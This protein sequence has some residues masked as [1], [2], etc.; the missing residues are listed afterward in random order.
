MDEAHWFQRWLDGAAHYRLSY[1]ADPDDDVFADETWQKATPQWEK[2]PYLIEEIKRHR[3]DARNDSD[4]FQSYKALRLN[5]GVPDVHQEVL[6]TA[7]DWKLCESDMEL[8]EGPLVW[9]IDMGGNSAMSAITGYWPVTGWFEKLAAFP[10]IPDL[11]KRGNQDGVG[12]MYNQMHRAGELIITEGRTVDPSILMTHAMEDWGPP[13]R[14]VS[15]TYQQALILDELEKAEIPVTTYTGRRNGFLDGGEDVRRFR[16]RC[17]ENKVKGRPSLL[18]R[19][20]MGGARVAVGNGGAKLAKHGDGT[21]RNAR[22]R[23]DVIAALVVAVAEGDR[24][25]NIE[26]TTPAY[27]PVFEVF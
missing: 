25:V 5:L 24:L 6:L 22:H 12:D 13:D 21:G 1:H 10:G 15:D 20:A 3:D 16:R 9:G 18:L 26:D 4:E 19:Y 23:D 11:T 8:R 7:E 14:V 2:Y 27:T 17:F